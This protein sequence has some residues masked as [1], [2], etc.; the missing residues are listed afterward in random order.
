VISVYR[1]QAE[2]IREYTLQARN[3][4]SVQAESERALSIG[5]VDEFQGMEKDIIILSLVVNEPDAQLSGFLRTAERINVAMSRA[6]RLLIIVGSTHNYTEVKSA[7][8][9]MYGKVLAVARKRGHYVRADDSWL[10]E[11]GRRGDLG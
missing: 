11:G 9:G 7:A 1:G 3:R 5:T 10:S 2:L 4:I 8:S 6:R